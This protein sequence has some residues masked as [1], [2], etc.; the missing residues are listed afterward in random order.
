MSEEPVKAKKLSSTN[1]ILIVGILI[2]VVAIAVVGFL[3][4]NKKDAAPAAVA[5]P[6]TGNLIV[7]DGFNPDAM[8]QKAADNMFEVK[9]SA[10]WNFADGA[11][12][13]DEAYVANS[14]ANSQ[15]F[16]FDILL[17]GTEEVIYSSP[18]VPIGSAVRGITLN[19]NLEKGDYVCVCRYNLLNDDE[20]IADSVL[21]TVRLHVA[22]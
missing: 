9:M 12:Q 14:E 6:G 4:L 3:I 17:E 7:D 1:V 2:V 19:K 16:Y 5:G 8:K 13:S 10:D 11:S 22:E 21:V 18:I 15:A 20:T